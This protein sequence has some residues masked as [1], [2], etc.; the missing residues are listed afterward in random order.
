M[1]V[2]IP[3]N[4]VEDIKIR[5]ELSE[6]IA[7]YGIQVKTA[8]SSKKACCPFHNEKSPSF[9]IND[10]K[11]FYHCFGCG[12]SG[13]AISF[14][15]KMD[16]LS[17][18][19]A[20]KKLAAPLGIEF[21]AKEDP[22]AAGR[23]RLY[24][25]MAEAAAFYHR[26]LMQ[27]KEASGAREYLESRGLDAVAEDWLIGYAPVGA[28]VMLKWAAKHGFKPEELEKAGIVKLPTRSGDNGYHRF[29]GR[30]IFTVRD[31]Q[32]RVV[33]FSGRQ[34]VPDKR[35]GKYVNSP[36]TPVF[37]KSNVLFAFDRASAAIARMPKREGIVCEGQID[38]I[39]LHMSGFT[40]AVASQGTAFT[41]EHAALLKK[42][43]DSMLVMYDDDTA[44][45]AAAVK[46][47]RL[48]LE[49]ELPVRTVTLPGGEDPDSFLRQYGP[50]E[51]RRRMDAAQSVVAFQIGVERA[52]ESNPD[53]IDAVSRISKSVLETIACARSPVL[54]ATLLAEA[55]K[56]MR[57]PVAA[58][59]E[60]LSNMRLK[61]QRSRPKTPP[62]QV[63]AEEGDVS[64]PA[65]PEKKPLPQVREL[66]VSPPPKEMAFLGFLME[67]EYDQELASLLARHL[68]GDVFANGF[69]AGFFEQWVDECGSGQDR[70]RLFRE[71]LGAEEC[72]WFDE[73]LLLQGKT[74]ASGLDRM[75]IAG[76]FIRTL[77]C[78]ALSRFRGGLPAGPSGD[79][80][81]M[82]ISVDMKRLPTAELDEIE[83]I[84]LKYPLMHKERGMS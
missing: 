58:L 73:V 66:V 29:G 17:F 20:V 47:A 33:A 84:V 1:P 50:D 77:W 57:L 79:V 26:C 46:V 81:R 2:T 14:V 28:S 31:R 18:T 21:D 74:L 80:T 27:S 49:L 53:S 32:G 36:E 78:A 71:S 30:L 70:L 12:E 51:L 52:R 37:R 75:E 59:E 40:N 38:V 45:H 11:G 82:M 42:V 67:N 15:Q 19:E 68:K 83:G 64:S 65:A 23:K 56:L 34:I 63:A 8:G 76:D 24:V 60:E 13:D 62:E 69:T 72:K 35:S 48:L 41:G 4:V 5:T 7:S 22:E 44:G 25:V 39:R 3:E 16:G 9:H 10:R 54:R 55:A 61:T 43:A 6:L